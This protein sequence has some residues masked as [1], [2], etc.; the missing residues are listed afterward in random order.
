MF[1]CFSDY[2]A[3]GTESLLH[4][5]GPRYFG[6]ALPRAYTSFLEIANASA[7]GTQIPMWRQAYL[8]GELRC[9][10]TGYD[11]VGFATR[12]SRSL[13]EQLAETCGKAVGKILY[14]GDEKLSTQWICSEGVMLQF[15]QLL[16]QQQ[17]CWVPMYKRNRIT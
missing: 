9:E 14:T 11:S 5:S 7:E 13:E 3:T 10:P 4:C 2:P 17:G 15:G 8:S 6:T 1:T 16:K 12:R